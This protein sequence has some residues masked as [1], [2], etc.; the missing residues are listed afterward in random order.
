MSDNTI[1][2]SGPDGA[3]N[4]AAPPPPL[5]AT[6]DPPAAAQGTPGVEGKKSCSVQPGPGNP[7][8]HGNQGL[9]GRDG[10]TPGNGNQIKI[11]LAVMEGHY[12]LTVKGGKAGNGGPGGTGGTGQDGGPAGPKPSD[13]SPGATGPAGAGGKGGTGGD[14]PDGGNAGDIYITFAQGSPTF[15]ATIEPGSGGTSGT[16]GPG[17]APGA[18]TGGGGS[19]GGGDYGHKGVAGKGG[20]FFLN[21]RKQNPS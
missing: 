18:G 19:L 20:Q 8:V 6:I 7:G 4:G 10:G 17:G 5:P 16:P 12:V 9:K 3:D 2:N 15:A 1:I 21:G 13:C 14:G 11:D